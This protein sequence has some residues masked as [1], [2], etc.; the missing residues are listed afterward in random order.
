MRPFSTRGPLHSSPVQQGAGRGLACSGRS[1]A[2]QSFC[3][4]T[5]IQDPVGQL[6]CHSRGVPGP[7]LSSQAPHQGL[8]T[9]FHGGPRECLGSRQHSCSKSHTRSFCLGSQPPQGRL[10]LLG[11]EP[12]A[13]AKRL[14]QNLCESLV[15][16]GRGLPSERPTAIPSPVGAPGWPSPSYLLQLG[17]VWA[18]PEGGTVRWRRQ[19]PHL[20]P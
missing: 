19:A 1:P 15:V 5:H 18:G 2:S 3:A 10:V 7:S 8:M 12:E 20:A 4:W 14:H 13:R 16:S 9:H 6:L 11:Q 17:R